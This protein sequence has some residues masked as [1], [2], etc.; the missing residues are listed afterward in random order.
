MQTS[1]RKTKFFYGWVM[2]SIA[3][4][5]SIMTQPGQTSGVSLFNPSF[6]LDLGLTRTQLTGAYAMGT[7][8]ASLTMTY[9]GAQMDRLGIRKVMGVVVVLFGLVCVYTG[10]VSGFW[11][12][13][14]AFLFLRMFGQGSLSLLSQNT[15]AMWFDKRLGLA[16]SIIAIGFSLA[17]AATP[18]FIFWLIS[19][20]GW[21]MAYP[22]LGGIVVAVMLPLVLFVYV[23]RPEEM[24]Q[25][26]DG[27]WIAPTKNHSEQPSSYQFTLPEAMKTPA[28]WIISGLMFSISMIGTAI[29]FNALF[30]FGEFGLTHQETVAV[31][32][33]A[34]FTSA[35]AQLFAGWL[36]DNFPLRWLVVA[37][38]AGQAA[39]LILLLFVTSVWTAT[40]FA[41]ITGLFNAVHQGAIGP[42]WARYYGREH[43]GKIR[44]STFTFTVAGSSLGPF[45]MGSLFDLTGSY[46]PSISIFIGIYLLFVVLTPF[47]KRPEP[48]TGS[49]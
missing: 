12:L 49:R 21:R 8:L 37:N 43:I 28:Y 11:T 13:F 3:V 1:K 16:N 32:A 25:Q 17:S 38:A 33:T 6:E 29:L 48:L 5:G 42:L 18:P 31:L 30:L 14:L 4:I 9:V 40:L 39:A 24:N 26:M 35:I 2:L 10:F 36:A 44:G 45:V 23:N 7:F 22:L 15:A 46:T 47:A 27:G 20:F 34:G 19:T 41:I